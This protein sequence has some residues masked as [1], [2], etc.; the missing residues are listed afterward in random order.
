MLKKTRR[1]PTTKLKKN[2]RKHAI[3]CLK[4]SRRFPTTKLKKKSFWRKHAIACLRIHKYDIRA[5][6]SP[7]VTDGSLVTCVMV[8]RGTDEA[9]KQH[10]ASYT[11]RSFY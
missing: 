8:L 2:W 11:S 1:L 3:A 6:V 7:K 5:I 9:S 10:G 4:L